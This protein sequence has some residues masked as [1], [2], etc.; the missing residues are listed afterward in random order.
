[1]PVLVEIKET[2]DRAIDEALR[3]FRKKMEAA[4]VMDIYNKKQYF[5][6]P[7]TEKREKRK[8]RLK[9]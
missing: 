5:T 4:E 2:S 8:A 1:M 7:S 9:S 3:K 6:K